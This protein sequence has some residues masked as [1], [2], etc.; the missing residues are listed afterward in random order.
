M[1]FLFAKKEWRLAGFLAFAV[2]FVVCQFAF[3][4]LSLCTTQA[5]LGI[6]SLEF[7]G[8][9]RDARNIISSW[10][11]QPYRRDRAF[12]NTYLDFVYIPVYS[13]TL[14]IAV[15]CAADIF[16]RKGG[17]L[18]GFMAS[19][20]LALAWGQT[21][22]GL[23]DYLEDFAI[24]NSLSQ[25]EASQPWPALTVAFTLPK[26]ALSLGLGA[27]YALIAGGVCFSDSACRQE[28]KNAFL[29]LGHAIR[30]IGRDTA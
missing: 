10:D 23:L 26:W 13:T 28:A 29:A 5:R 22:A 17:S 1:W 24:L 21:A 18:A 2:M 6:I 16:K 30:T 11:D 9:E 8:T 15:I 7:A 3:A 19:W 20:G 4:K 12:A 14:G 25:P 27:P